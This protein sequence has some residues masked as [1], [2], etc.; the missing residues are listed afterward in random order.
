MYLPYLTPF[1]TAAFGRLQDEMTIS[2][3]LSGQKDDWYQPLA[4]TS[5]FFLNHLPWTWIKS[6]SDLILKQSHFRSVAGELLLVHKSWSFSPYST[7]PLEHKKTASALS[8]VLF[9]H[10]LAWPSSSEAVLF[11]GTWAPN[12][13]VSD[14]FPILSAREQAACLCLRVTSQVFEKFWFQLEDST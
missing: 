9:W 5:T 12:T 3:N 13:W 7:K 4:C 8:D 6:Y 1:E 14:F 10:P 2:I 11:H